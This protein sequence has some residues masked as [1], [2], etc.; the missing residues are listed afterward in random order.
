[1]TMAKV[2]IQVQ[3]QANA[4]RNE[5]SGLR[6]EILQVKIAAPPVKNKANLELIAYLSHILGISKINL[7]IE[8]GMT[9]KRKSIGIT[10]L[11]QNQVSERI[12]RLSHIHTLKKV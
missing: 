2:I 11:T 1:M 12:Y 6:D 5:F 4:H 8:K 10:G 9:S 7:S 3:V